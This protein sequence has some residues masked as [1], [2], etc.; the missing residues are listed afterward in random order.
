MAEKL[1]FMKCYLEGL[2]FLHEH[3]IFHRV[4]IT[5]LN[6]LINHLPNRDIIGLKTNPIRKQLRAEGRLSYAL[7]DFNL[8]IMLPLG[9]P[10]LSYLLPI[11]ELREPRGTR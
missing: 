4:D 5:W 6:A 9:K 2:A 8:S 3:R 7:F 11:E 10:L 1:N